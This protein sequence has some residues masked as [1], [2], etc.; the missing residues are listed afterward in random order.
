MKRAPL[1]VGNWKMYKTVAE[2]LD[3]AT[4]VKNGVAP[5]VRAAGVEVVLAPPF[6]SLHPIGK[7]LE[8][9]T[10]A[11]AAQDCFWETQGAFTGEVS[12]AMLVDV[13]CRFVIVGHSERRQFFGETD[14]SVNLKA[15][16]AQKAGLVPIVCVG[17]TEKERD[18][19][20]TQGRVL[21]QL[22]GS[23]SGFT[24]DLMRNTVI[25]YEPVW[26][27]G[28]GR[29]ATTAQAQEVH[30]LIRAHLHANFGE[31]A[32]VVRILYGGSVKP[33]NIAGLMHEP[34]VDGALVGGA[35]LRAEEFL[36]IVRF[37]EVPV[38]T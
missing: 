23:L 22:T 10:V 17:E 24:P 2:G 26:A 6:P 9:S 11:L 31:V 29:V 38:S 36:Q 27:I 20:E 4:A 1:F 8:G 30:A 7:R 32:Q 34:D 35:S 18:A 5:T 33:N 28:T 12:P 3:L 21:S 15:K 25:A 14:A 13:G 37:H 19:G 16:A